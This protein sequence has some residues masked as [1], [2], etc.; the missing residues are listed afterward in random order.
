VSVG[1]SG[2]NLHAPDEWVSVTEL[3]ALTGILEKTAVAFCG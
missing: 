2:G 3:V 1:A